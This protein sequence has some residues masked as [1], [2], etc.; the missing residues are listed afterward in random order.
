MNLNG[1]HHVTAIASDAQRNRNFYSDILGLRL[2]KVTV[3]FDDPSAYHLYY[4]DGIGSPGTILTFFIWQGASAGRAGTGQPIT[5]AFSIPQASLGYW[6]HRL[7]DKG[8]QAIGPEERFGEK[9]LL[10]RDPDG[11]TVELVTQTDD[12]PFDA[13]KE[14][15]VPS[16][17]AIRG[18][19]GV[20]LLESGF[21]D[22]ADFLGKELNM[23]QTAEYHGIFRYTM[24]KSSSYID[25]KV[26]PGMMSGALG[27]GTIHHVA[28]ST[29]DDTEQREW[30]HTLSHH[31]HNVST[32]M[33]R[34]YFHSIYFREPGGALFEIA[35]DQPGFTIDETRAELGSSL[36]LPPWYEDERKSIE[37]ALPPYPRSV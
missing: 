34:V 14:G 30:L 33:D 22:T 31:G 17:N 19:H 29:K 20:T 3:N 11:M 15:P 12:R 26:A 2:V 10:L 23:T 37:A 16:E 4:G 25:L 9:F 21:E 28:F 13:W 27:T 5:V 18:L 7:Q 8:V 1:L 24:G 32:V 6:I 36:Q 35:T